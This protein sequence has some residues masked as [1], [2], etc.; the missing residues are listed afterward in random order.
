MNQSIEAL[1]AIF[2][3]FYL[4]N[5]SKYIFFLNFQLKNRKN[6]RKVNIFSKSKSET[7]QKYYETHLFLNYIDKK[8]RIVQDV[9]RL[10]NNS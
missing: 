6:Y 4:Y 7:D 1:E 9:T 2:I 3:N 8:S 10:E 5:Y